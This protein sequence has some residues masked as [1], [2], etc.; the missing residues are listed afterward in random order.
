[1]YEHTPPTPQ[2][3]AP[4][5]PPAQRILGDTV[6]ARPVRILLECILVNLN[7]YVRNVDCHHQHLYIYYIC[8]TRAFLNFSD[9]CHSKKMVIWEVSSLQRG[10]WIEIYDQMFIF[11][12]FQSLE[13]LSRLNTY[14][15]HAMDAST[16]ITS[17]NEKNQVLDWFR[18]TWTCQVISFRMTKIWVSYDVWIT[19][20]LGPRKIFRVPTGVSLLLIYS[21]ASNPLW[22]YGPSW[23]VTGLPLV[24]CSLS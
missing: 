11:I 3:Q 15:F 18:S 5:L 1:M 6:N 9:S 2:D 8:C 20:I 4:P 21:T 10:L 19:V 14:L 7:V 24:V 12:I 16:Y 13:M 17:Y 23:S 22:E